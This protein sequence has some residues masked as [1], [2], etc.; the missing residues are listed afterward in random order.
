M[1]M[2]NFSG[3]TFSKKIGLIIGLMLLSLLAFLPNTV[4]AG[5]KNLPS[6]LQIS[7]NKVEP[8]FP[9]KLKF[10]FNATSSPD[11]KYSKIEL[12]YR[13]VGDVAT[14]VRVQD[15]T[16]NGTPSGKFNINFDIDTQKEYVP[17][18]VRLNYYWTIFDQTGNSFDTKSQE[19]TLKDERFAFRELTSGLVTVRWYEGSDS[20]GKAVLDKSVATMDKLSQLYGIKATS[21]I[22]IH[23]YPNQ[24]AFYQA[25][26]PN[27]GEFVGGQAY[28]EYGAISLLIEPNNL[29]EVGRSVPHEISHLVVYQA[30]KNP[31]NRPPL[32]LDEG[33]A[34]NNQDQVEGFLTEAFQRGFDKHSLQP[35]R[36]ISGRFPSD[37]Q[38]FY[39]SYGE[40]VNV[41]QYIL[42]KYGQDKMGQLLTI[43]KDGVS[44]DEALKTVLGV[45]SD[46]LDRQWKESLGYKLPE[47]QA[48]TAPATTQPLGPTQTTPAA[49]PSTSAVLPTTAPVVIAATTLP[50]YTAVEAVV[51]SVR[52]PFNQQTNSFSTPADNQNSL[53]FLPFLMIGLGVVLS[54]V[55]GVWYFATKRR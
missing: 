45:T 9:L 10:Q 1:V 36:T 2:Y 41:V 37:S 50:T 35:L 8:S 12:N 54:G 30:T 32:W 15:L 4:Q 39:Q 55:A 29:K 53:N 51:T 34:V 28:I 23:I 22:N 44:Y 42:K 38:L 18:G 52:T 3:Q 24:Q 47:I 43:F 49:Q 11:K 20:F 48:T 6:D 26:P 19:F 14:R 5:D 33:L 21:P 16:D 13:L 25:L 40:S 17:P 27:T 31:Y 7:L 46:E